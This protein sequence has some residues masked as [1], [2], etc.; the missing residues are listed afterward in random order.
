[1]K[2][3]YELNESDRQQITAFMRGEKLPV[4]TGLN[5]ARKLSGMNSITT[6]HKVYR[7]IMRRLW[8]L[9]KL[10]VVDSLYIGSRNQR[11][12]WLKERMK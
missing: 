7:N 4:C 1:M 12:W 6:N 10:G 8:E 2:I 5:I 3:N 9:E 11:V